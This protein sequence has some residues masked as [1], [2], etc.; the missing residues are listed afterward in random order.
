MAEKIS[1]AILAGGIGSRFH[2]M[3]K[4]KIIIGGEMIISRIISVIRDIFDEIII[5][6]NT[7]SEF[8]EF[9]FCKIVKDEIVN[10]GPLGGIHAALKSSSNKAVFILGGDMPFPDKRIIR[11][12]IKA[13]DNKICD[14]LIPRI[15]DYIEPLFSVYSVSLVKAIEDHLARNSRIAVADFVRTVNVRYLQLKKSTINNRAFTNINSPEDIIDAG[16]RL[17]QKSTTSRDFRKS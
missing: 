1:A 3:I 12:V 15:E 7:P 4:P 6:T 13:Y 5:V 9:S 2:G 14:A 10:S 8:E 11:K 17:D 16:E